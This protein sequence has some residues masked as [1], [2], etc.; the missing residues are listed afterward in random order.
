VKSTSYEAPRYAVFS[1]TLS[2]IPLRFKYSPQHPILKH[3]HSEYLPKCQRP[4]FITHAG[5]IY[6]M[7]V[8][9]ITRIQSYLNFQQG[10]KYKILAAEDT[11]LIK[12]DLL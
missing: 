1:T 11:E 9:G 7:V 12:P 8:A 4:S 6:R 3:P 2:L 5:K 10:L